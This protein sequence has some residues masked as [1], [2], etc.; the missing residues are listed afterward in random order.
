MVQTGGGNFAPSL[1]RW[2]FG[3]LQQ[4]RNDRR[5]SLKSNAGANIRSEFRREICAT[6]N[7][8]MQI[9]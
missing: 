7:Q 2:S 4:I 6:F 9:S 3:W 8:L 1:Y 5:L